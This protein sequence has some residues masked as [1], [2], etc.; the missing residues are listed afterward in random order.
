MDRLGIDKNRPKKKHFTLKRK[1]S[2]EENDKSPQNG[3]TYLGCGKSCCCPKVMLLPN[4]D[5]Q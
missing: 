2:I 4:E 5:L 1:E 3:S